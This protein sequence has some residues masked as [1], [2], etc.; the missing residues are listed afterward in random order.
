MAR[1]KSTQAQ[2]L[3][4][5]LHNWSGTEFDPKFTFHAKNDA[6]A[7]SKVLGWARYHSYNRDSVDVRKATTEESTYSNWLHNEWV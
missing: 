7:H 6:E 4:T 5:L 3:Y 2:Q 1:K